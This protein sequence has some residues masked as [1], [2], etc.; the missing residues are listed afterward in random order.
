MGS[1][2]MIPD[3]KNVRN[4]LKGVRNIHFASLSDVI[5]K[6]RRQS[7]FQLATT[8]TFYTNLT[9]GLNDS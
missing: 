6:G 8:L 7:T 3:E 5:E 4:I 9:W 1:K 2:M